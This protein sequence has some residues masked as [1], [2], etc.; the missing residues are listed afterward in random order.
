MPR[1][2]SFDDCV[3]LLVKFHQHQQRGNEHLLDHLFAS[4]KS[5]MRL[6]LIRKDGNIEDVHGDFRLTERGEQYLHDALDDPNGD[7]YGFGDLPDI[8]RE[9]FEREHKKQRS[10]IWIPR[11]G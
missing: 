9:N 11:A 5:A 7:P 4:L 1:F 8:Q 3:V 10:G 6:G 2:E